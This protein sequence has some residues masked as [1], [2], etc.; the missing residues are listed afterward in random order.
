MRAIRTTPTT[1][2]ATQSRTSRPY[3]QAVRYPPSQTAAV[4]RGAAQPASSHMFV[5]PSQRPAVR[6]DPELFERERL[7]ERTKTKIRCCF[8]SGRSLELPATREFCRVHRYEC[9]RF[10]QSYGLIE[11][12]YIIQT[13]AVRCCPRLNVRATTCRATHIRL[14]EPHVNTRGG[15]AAYKHRDG[16][17]RFYRSAREFQ[18]SRRSRGTGC[19]RL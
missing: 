13:N 15:F 1:P 2:V 5:P 17:G 9:Q 16:L 12:L 8:F 7:P 10:V 18:R 11:T 6:D 14:G 19:L 4:D 3:Q